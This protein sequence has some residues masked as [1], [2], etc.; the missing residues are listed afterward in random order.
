MS[1]VT[2]LAGSG[3]V[4]TK[5]KTICYLVSLRDQSRASLCQIA[6]HPQN[7]DTLQFD[8][9]SRVCRWKSE[10]SEIRRRLRQV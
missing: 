1:E 2:E 9:A 5:Q 4:E 7:K 3:Q 6:L 10:S 8:L